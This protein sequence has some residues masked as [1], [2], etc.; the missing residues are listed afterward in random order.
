M[1][2]TTRRRRRPRSRPVRRRRGVVA[3]PGAAVRHARS[4]GGAAVNS[5]P[6]SRGRSSAGSPG[7]R[8]SG[9]GTATP[10]CSWTASTTPTTT[11]SGCS[12]TCART[13]RTSTPG[14]SSRA[15]LARLGPPQGTATGGAGVARGWGSFRWRML[16]LNTRWLLS[17]HADRDLVEPPAVTRIAGGRPWKFGFLQH[18]VIKD[19]LS[20]WL[21]QRDI[22]LFVVSTPAELASVAGDGTSYIVTTKETRN[23]G[24]PRFDRL[25]EKG[26]RGPAEGARPRDRRADLADVADPADRPPDPAPDGRPALRRLRV[27]PDLGRPPPVG[28]DPRRRRE[29]RLAARLHA[30][31]EPP[32]GARASWTCRGGWSRSASPA[33]TSRAC[34]PGAP[35]SSPTTRRSRSTSPTSTGR[36]SISSSTARHMPGARTWAGRATSST[37]ATGSG[38]SSRTWP[39]AEKAVVAADPARP[40]AAR[41]F[42]ARI[43]ATFPVRD[44]GASAR[45]VA[46]IEELSRPYEPPR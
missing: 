34:T 44:G 26:R 32:V 45:V 4:G 40:A 15:E 5:W 31:S 11:A 19:D 29:A 16:M 12:S 41:E 17:S 46:A 9:T 18:G 25:L 43:D 20:L 13:G 37:S 22:D 30:P 42:Q 24:L 23:T 36:S 21:N 1:R 28:A 10:G 3:A 39:S 14:S 38:R 2:W 8:S 33:R 6:A 35:C 7:R 27:L